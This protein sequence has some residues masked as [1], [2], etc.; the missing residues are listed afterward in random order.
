MPMLEDDI[1]ALAKVHGISDSA[2][3]NDVLAQFPNDDVES[4]GE[5]IS[6]TKSKKPHWLEP[7]ALVAD[8]E[9]YRIEAQRQYVQKHGADATAAHLAKFGLTLGHVKK[10]EA[11]LSGTADDEGGYSNPWSKAFTIIRTKRVSTPD[12]S[13]P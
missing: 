6:R 10:N 3:K 9:C 8:D 7:E 13:T 1:I 4:F 11:A 12:I 5:W 2:I